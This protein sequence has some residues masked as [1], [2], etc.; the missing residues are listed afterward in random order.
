MKKCVFYSM[1]RIEG[2]PCAIQHTGYHDK[3][4]WYYK[5][6]SAWQAI[7]PDN[8]LMIAQGRTRKEAAEKANTPEMVGRLASFMASDVGQRARTH[9]IKAVEVAEA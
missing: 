1:M 6:E 8:G 9:F 3:G 4:I 5:N 2:I 7:S